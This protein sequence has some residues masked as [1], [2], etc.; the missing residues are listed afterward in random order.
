MINRKEL[1]KRVTKLEGKKISLPLP[2]IMEVQR[3]LLELLSEEKPSAVLALL[4]KVREE[5][6]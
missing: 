1:A 6:G 2:Q 3:I 4:E 5:K